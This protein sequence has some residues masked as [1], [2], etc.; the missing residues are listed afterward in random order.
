MK[1]E[2]Q[3]ERT[4][5]TRDQDATDLQQLRSSESGRL[6]YDKGNIADEWRIVNVLG[7]IEIPIF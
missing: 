4:C 3:H 7:F 5:S 6:I 2:S 1:E